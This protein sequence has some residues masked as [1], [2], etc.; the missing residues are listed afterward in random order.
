MSSF[1]YKEISNPPTLCE[2]LKAARESLGFSLEQ[3]AQKTN[4]ATK[5]LAAIESA[6]YSQLPGEIYAKSFLKV[7]ANFL[8]LNPAEILS[9]YQSEEKIY[10]KTRKSAIQNLKK[11]VERISR[12]HLLVTTKI[13]RS[14]II[15]FLVLVCL[16]YLGL[17]MKALLA[18]PKLVIDQP[19]NN[20]ITNEK[21]V[22]VSGAVE[23]E[24]ALDING[25]QV[26]VDPS[27]RFSET[28]NLQPGVNII[29]ISAQK[30]HGQQIKVYRQVVAN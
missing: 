20:L 7:Y 18:P 23:S 9:L 10:G 1:R 14:L 13:I 2:R 25:Q 12:F 3:A 5:Y 19:I 28:I 30:K 8:H 16:F 6:D 22:Q 26:S 11:P 24:T 29:E 17:K 15:L 27:G 4:I 21:Y